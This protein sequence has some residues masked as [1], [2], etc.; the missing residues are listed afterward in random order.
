ML[1][2]EFSVTPTAAFPDLVL[3]DGG[4]RGKVSEVTLASPIVLAAG[5]ALYVSVEMV[6]HYEALPDGGSPFDDGGTALNTSV[7]IDACR[8]AFDG[9]A[10]PQVGIDYWSNAAVEPYAWADMVADFGFPALFTI[11]AFGSP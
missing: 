11:R 1:R 4:I 7:C 3:A 5:E 9:G 6:G 10:A 8:T 2:A